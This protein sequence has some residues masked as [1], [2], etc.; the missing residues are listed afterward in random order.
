MAGSEY[1]GFHPQSAGHASH[2]P[3]GSVLLRFPLVRGVIRARCSPVGRGQET[4]VHLQCLLSGVK[5]EV[6]V[7][8]NEEVLLIA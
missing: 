4:Q 8:L 3:E 2:L 6:V 1:P 5:Q 7:N